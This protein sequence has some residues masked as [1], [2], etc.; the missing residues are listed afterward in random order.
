MKKNVILKIDKKEYKLPVVIGTEKEKGI[1][2]SKLRAESGYIT[3]DPGYNNT[4]SCESIITY[5]NGEKGILRYRGIPI[6][7]LAQKS[8]F[9][10]V[11]DLLIWGT[12]PDKRMR[13]RFTDL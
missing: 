3:L 2:I 9:I 13:K 8:D 11:A 1:D 4:G 7:E 5:T 6:E 12:L 10:E